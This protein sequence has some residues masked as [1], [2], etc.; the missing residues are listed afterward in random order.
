METQQGLL[1]TNEAVNGK[2]S[3]LPDFIHVGPPRCGTTWLH[4]ALSPH[5]CLPFEK[6][7]LFFEYRY[8]RGIRW[9]ADLFKDAPPDVRC[10][11]IAPSYFANAVVRERIRKHL[12]DCKIIC[13]FRDPATRLY[14][15]YRMLRRGGT[16][17]RSINFTRYYRMIVHWGGD[18]CGYATQLRRWQENF[19]EHRV[20]AMFYED[21]MSE[22]QEYLDQVSDYIG[23]PR[24]PL[25]MSPVADVK[26]MSVWSR[27]RDNR[28]SRFAASS[29]HWLA[30]HGGHTL[31]QRAKQ[32]SIGHRVRGLLVEDYESLS[33]SSI[34]EIRHIM[35][36][37][38][39]ELERMTGRD[40]SGW[41]PGAVSN[42]KPVREY[43][44]SLPGRLMNRQG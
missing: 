27:P 43:A 28:A 20:L 24:L 13:T 22:P 30:Q 34:D 18:L 12:P 4:E 9:Y 6:E 44:R 42:G 8:E 7:T 16:L 21:L 10:G 40:L 14:S 17:E 35:L 19:G 3:R 41:K 36:P 29:F 2:A 31:I 38:T 37:E 1:D 25:E 11:E 32:T 39:E 5:V 23:T 26:I 33:Q 15:Q